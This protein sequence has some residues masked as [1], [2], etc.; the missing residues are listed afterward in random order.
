MNRFVFATLILSIGLSTNSHA[1]EIED[2]FSD[3]EFVIGSSER[4]KIE[5]NVFISW[6]FL[7]LYEQDT[8]NNSSV[9][10][11]SHGSFLEKNSR[12]QFEVES[13]LNVS[14]QIKI[15]G[16]GFIQQESQ[17]YLDT[18]EDITKTENELLE[19]YLQWSNRASDLSI[20]L[21]RAKPVWSNGF[22]WS[23]ANL[24]YPYYERPHFDEDKLQQQKGW[25]LVQIEKYFE[26]WS[27]SALVA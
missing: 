3:G 13:K 7:G 2:P 14:K 27:F 1:Q 20:L 17:M 19:G 12:L 9:L 10:N 11:S 5:N 16:R 26:N 25:D 24:L 15:N 21:G 6:S 4:S 8:K 23:P 22:N 18:N